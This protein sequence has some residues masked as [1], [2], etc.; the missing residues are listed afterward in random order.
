MGFGFPAAIGA[1]FAQPDQTVI[2]IV[3]DGGFQMTLNELSTAAVHRLPVKVVVINNRYLGMVRQ[4]QNLFYDN[5]LSGVDLQGNP[6]FTKLAE[7]YGVKGFRIR[8]NADVSRI[9]AAALAYTEGPCLI[10]AEVIREDNVF[11]MVPSGA[12]YD[13][14][15]ISPPKAQLEKPRGST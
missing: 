9:I 13:Q 14:M 7:S 12:G 3:G 8:R 2:A 11:P 4:W 6:N 10:E 5:R 15:I 1:Q